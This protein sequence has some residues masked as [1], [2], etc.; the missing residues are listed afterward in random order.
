VVFVPKIALK[1][2]GLMHVFHN[3]SL[4]RNRRSLVRRVAVVR[5]FELR[6][7]GIERKEGQEVV[8]YVVLYA[9]RQYQDHWCEAKRR[10]YT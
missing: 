6:R 7:R 2:L 4:E 5:P 9:K 1:S 8:R 10:A 3:G